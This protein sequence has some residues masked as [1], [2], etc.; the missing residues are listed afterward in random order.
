MGVTIPTAV[1][2][3]PKYGPKSLIKLAPGVIKLNTAISN[4]YETVNKCLNCKKIMAVIR[5]QMT[6]STEKLSR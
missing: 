4:G 2:L 5:G 1:A 6:V 3:R